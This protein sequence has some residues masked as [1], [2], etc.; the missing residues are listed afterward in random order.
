MIRH[1]RPLLLPL[2]LAL[3]AC[4]TYVPVPYRPMAESGAAAGACGNLEADARYAPLRGRVALDNLAQQTDAMRNDARRPTRSERAALEAWRSTSD[5]CRRSTIAAARDAGV[6]DAQLALDTRL[7]EDLDALGGELAAGRIS[8]GDYAR[9]RQS[10]ADRYN[11]A[12]ARLEGSGEAPRYA[13]APPVYYVA[14]S[15]YAAPPYYAPPPYYY[16]PW[17]PAIGGSVWYGSGWHG[18]HGHGGWGVGVGF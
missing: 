4:T 5:Q 2:S 14:P 16:Q 17:Y 12:A 6:P 3:A 8:Y 15:Y 7:A 18:R 13:V 10:L 9:R 11:D 1:A